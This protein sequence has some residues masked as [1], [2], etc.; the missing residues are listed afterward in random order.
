M[1][2]LLFVPADSTRK[3]EKALACGAD[4]II[5]DLEDSVAAAA[6][7]AARELLR[8]T[9]QGL[10]DRSQAEMPR[11]Y[12]RVNALDTGLTAADL[13]CLRGLRVDG[14]MLPKAE[15]AGCVRRL[16]AMIGGVEPSDHRGAT[17]IIVVAT[18]TAKA[19]F[20]LPSYASAGPRLAALTWGAEDLRADIGARD[21]RSPDGRHTEPF[22]LAR[23]LC[24]FAAVAAGVE[25]IDTV[26]PNFRDEAGFK[27]ECDEALR[28]GFTG[29]M[30][31]HPDQ[32]PII[33]EMFSPSPQA[34]ARAQA[35]VDAFA[36]AGD[37]GVIGLNGEMLD[38]PHLLHAQRLLA[39]A[40]R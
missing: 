31:I 30:A 22:R 40:G 2:S 26:F 13:E 21:N 33:N 19:I 29:K 34:V 24:L 39:R 8:E 17:R 18:E 16:S 28:D 3:I 27:Q 12:V 5:F 7:P 35:I 38:R 15:G 25:P 11:L 9:L 4:V 23:S 32:V 14:I 6:K 20:G 36:A 10:A 1:R 37:A